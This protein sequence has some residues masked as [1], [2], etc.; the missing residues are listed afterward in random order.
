[1]VPRA[2]WVGC[3]LGGRGGE[4][5]L[6]RLGLAISDDTIVR[7]LKRGA[8]QHLPNGDRLRIVGIGPWRSRLMIRMSG[9]AA[10]HAASHGIGGAHPEDIHD[11]ASL[12]VPSGPRPPQ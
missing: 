9:W 5:L 1:M 11:H 2:Q 8:P 12:Q 3:A 4:R 6:G 10:S 7:G